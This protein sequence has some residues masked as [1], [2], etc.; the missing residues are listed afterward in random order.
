VNARVSESEHYA[1]TL[2]L[3]YNILANNSN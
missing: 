3:L 2:P 1:F